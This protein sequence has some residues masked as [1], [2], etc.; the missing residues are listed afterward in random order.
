[1]VAQ[2]LIVS[3]VV[4]KDS[5]ERS[6]EINKAEGTVCPRCWNVSKEHDENG[7]CPRCQKVLNA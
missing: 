7:L 5:E 4:F 3:E 1:M 2:W 6:Y